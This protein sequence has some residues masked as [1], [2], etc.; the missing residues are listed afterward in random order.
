MMTSAERVRAFRL[1][2]RNGVLLQNKPMVGY[3]PIPTVTHYPQWKFQGFS[4]M[5]DSLECF[6]R[7][8]VDKATRV[9]YY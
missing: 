5:L 8:P 7:M 1:R 9:V 4:A 3:S 6:Q 2:K